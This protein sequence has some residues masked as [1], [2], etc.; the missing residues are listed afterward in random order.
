MAENSNIEWTD[1]TFNPWIGCTH[2]SE[3]CRFCYAEEMMDKRYGRV[4]WGKGKPRQRTSEANW[5]KPVQW[6]KAAEKAGIRTKV[7]CA[8]LADV[9]DE[10]VPHE[11]RLDLWRLIER[12][13]NLDWLLLT[14]RPQNIK[15]FQQWMAGADDISIANFPRNVWLGTTVE[16]QKAADERIPILLQVPAVVRFLSV[17]PMIGPVRLPD[18]FLSLGK[19]AWCIVGGESGP[20]A[21]PMHPDW[22][23]DLR[24]Q[25]NAAC[26]PFLFKQWGEYRPAESVQEATQ[27]PVVVPF[28]PGASVASGCFHM[29]HQ[30]ESMLDGKG[31]FAAT[32]CAMVKLGKHRAGRILDGRT[33][34]EY[35]TPEAAHV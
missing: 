26:V 28:A 23:R 4:E 24:D 31:R 18:E 10:E 25:C 13:P 7:F 3:G 5:K 2:V 29:P 35:P 34:D 16:N 9:F 12:T 14:K 27:Q 33:W 11:W 8:S 6:N 15:S 30:V 22:A 1:N 17:E 21:R 19:Q 20:G 32:N